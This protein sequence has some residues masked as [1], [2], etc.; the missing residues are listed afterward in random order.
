MKI[1]KE[2]DEL[3]LRIPLKQTSYDAI[4]E[5][6]GLVP[7]LVGVSDGRDFTINY[8]SELGYKDDIQL[9]MEA[10]NF[11]SEESLA[12]AC[13]TLGL[14]IWQYKRCKYCDKTL[15]GSFT[16]SDK[17]EQCMPCSYEEE[18]KEQKNA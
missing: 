9:G 6:K 16:Y 10:I 5:E 4:G 11:D 14:D 18:D 13:K 8:L 15:Y 7:N 1:T 2:N 17:G 3:V 12:E